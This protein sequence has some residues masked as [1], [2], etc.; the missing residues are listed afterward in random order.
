MIICKLTLR[1]TSLEHMKKLPLIF[2]LLLIFACKGPTDETKSSNSSEDSLSTEDLLPESLMESKPVV[3][4]LE[5]A[6]NLAELPL[7]CIN[8]EYPNKLGQTLENKNA[9]GEPHE[10]H[11]AFYGWEAYK[12]VNRS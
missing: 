9:M 5:E 10:L 1:G 3:L 7:A 11:P 8:T 4:T 6:N 12:I 2:G